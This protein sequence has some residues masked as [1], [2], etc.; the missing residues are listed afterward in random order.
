MPWSAPAPRMRE[1]ILALRHIWNSWQNE[2]KLD[3]AGDNYSFNLMSPFFNPG[4]IENPDII[5]KMGVNGR[6]YVREN[7]SEDK[8]LEKR[9]HKILQLIIARINFETERKIFLQK[10]TKG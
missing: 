9:V 6:K 2:T 5:S 4:P 10:T 8:V 7:F 3:F 1:Y